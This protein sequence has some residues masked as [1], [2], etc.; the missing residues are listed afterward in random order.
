MREGFSPESSQSGIH[1]YIVGK[2]SLIFENYYCLS[3]EELL[4][5]DDRYV[6]TRRNM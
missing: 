6:A 3:G 1:V 5:I 4:V 2:C